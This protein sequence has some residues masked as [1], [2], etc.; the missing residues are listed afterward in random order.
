MP[1][2]VGGR[3]GSAPGLAHRAGR[4]SAVRRRTLVLVAGEPTRPTA[5]PRVAARRG[6]R[7]APGAAGL[8]G[9]AWWS[10]CRRRPR[11]STRRSGGRAG[12]Y[13]VAAV[14]ATVD[15]TGARADARSTS[16]STRSVF[17]ELRPAGA[18]VVISHEAAHVATDAA[19]QLAAGVARSRGS[20]T[21]SR[22]ATSA[23]RCRRRPARSSRQVRREGAPRRA[24]ERRRLRR[25]AGRTS[26]LPTRRPG[27]RAGY[28]SSAVG[29]EALVAFYRSGRD[30]ADLRRRLLR[31]AFGC[32]RARAHRAVADRF[33]RLGRRDPDRRAGP[34]PSSPLVGG[35]AFVVLAVVAGA[36]GSG[37][38]GA[39]TP[40]HAADGV[41]REPDRTAPRTTL[42]GR[43][44]G[45]G[46]L[47]GLARGG[48]LARLHA[49]WW[50][51]GWS[52]AARPVVGRVVLAV[53]ACA[54]IGRLVTLPFARGAAAAP[55]RRR[56]D[57]TRPGPGGRVDVVVTEA[58][59][60]VSTSIGCW[61]SGRHRPALAARLAGGRGGVLA[62]LV[63]LG[64]F[65]YPLL[66]EPLFN[67]FTPLPDG[68]LRT[69]ILAAGRQRGRAGRRRPGGRRVS[70]Y[71]DPQR[72]RLGLR[73][74]PPGGRLRQPRRRRCRRTRRSRSSPTS[75]RT[76]GTTT[77]STA[78]L[79]GAAGALIGSA[80]WRCSAGALRGAGRPPVREPRRGAADA[81]AARHR[82][83]AGEPGAERRS[84]GRSRREPTSTRWRR[85]ATLRRSWPCSAS[86]RCGRWPTRRRRRGHSSG[87]ASH[88]T[89]LNGSRSPGSSP[90]AGLAGCQH[91]VTG[92]RWASS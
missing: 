86:S 66:V 78:A 65:V 54:L 30:G 37:A 41:H 80:C 62:A 17:R 6:H 12:S 29:E 32:Q 25:G 73:Q 70:P 77:C 7:R 83:A 24:P 88:P 84:A 19:D 31:R 2:S 18:Q 69:E 9:A 36:V 72:L 56:P 68:P 1:R 71:D 85:R 48:L 67:R 28:S 39:V 20:P 89:G 55:A 82:H 10:R 52:P 53:A 79:L 46:L 87:S 11:R 74:H 13:A 38:G 3:A 14:T 4:R 81:G 5:T 33:V 47:G 23:C 51:A 59:G 35:V 76:P 21:T 45:L 92:R 42:A 43:G 44:V 15:G 91:A 63:V 57:A 49:R 58:V 64:S 61:S 90:T 16:S 40:A 60:I 34:L 22:S 27:W 75:W 26:A 8:A 50:A